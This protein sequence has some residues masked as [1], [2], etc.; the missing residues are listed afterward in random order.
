MERKEGSLK[1]II[2]QANNFFPKICRSNGKVG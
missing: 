1:R 2:E